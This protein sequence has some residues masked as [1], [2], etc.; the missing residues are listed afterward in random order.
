V[1]KGEK[2]RGLFTEE[3]TLSLSSIGVLILYQAARQSD[4]E[5]SMFLQRIL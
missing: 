1:Q 5:I 3:K 2:Q 4:W